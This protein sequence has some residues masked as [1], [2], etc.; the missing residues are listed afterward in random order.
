MFVINLERRKK[1]EYR[2]H[3]ILAR[4]LSTLWC[5]NMHRIIG[6]ML[7]ALEPTTALILL[8]QEYR[9]QIERR[10]EK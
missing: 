2:I 5:E 3:D 8:L 10:N 7:S 6:L 9:H 1:D 4:E